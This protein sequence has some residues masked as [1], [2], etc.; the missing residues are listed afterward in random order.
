MSWRLEP[1]GM[2]VGTFSLPPLAAAPVTAA[3]DMELVRS[4][5]TPDASADASGNA[6]PRWP[7]IAQQRAD[8]FVRLMAQGGARSVTEIVVHVRGD[9]VTLDDGTPITESAL[10]RIAPTSFVRAL[11]HDAEG[12]P[13]NASA[14]RRHPSVRQRRV[15]KERDREC[16]NCGGELLLEY[17]HEPAFEHTGRTLVDELELRCATCHREHHANETP[18]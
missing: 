18:G 11:I 4:R 9:G 8:A 13:I 10:E 17:H 14:R 3:I 7:S 5:P 15:V 6:S 16:V 12:R 1:D 2:I